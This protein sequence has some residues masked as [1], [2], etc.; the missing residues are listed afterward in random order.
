LHPRHT[1]LLL[2]IIHIIITNL[3]EQHIA[4]FMACYCIYC[5]G[6]KSLHEAAFKEIGVNNENCHV[7]ISSMGGYY[8]AWLT[9]CCTHTNFC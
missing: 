2:G 5:I 3:S 8:Q 7:S 6:P 1:H 4:D 9:E